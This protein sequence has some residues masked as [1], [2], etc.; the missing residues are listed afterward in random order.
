MKLANNSKGGRIKAT[1]FLVLIALI[2]LFFVG[3]TTLYRD[4]GAPIDLKGVQFKEGETHYGTVLR[5]LG[6]PGKVS[7]VTKGLAFLYEHTLANEKQLGIKLGKL[8]KAAFAKAD[9]N[10]QV[11]LMVFDERGVLQSQKFQAYDENLGIG[12]G[13]QFLIAVKSEVSTSH[14]EDTIGPNQWGVSLLR[15]LPEI[16]NLSQS[17]DTGSAGLEQ[18]GTPTHVGQH[19]LELRS[20]SK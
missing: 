3:C 13:I 17:L 1:Y 7:A 16:M 15:P 6:P 4:I 11:L 8:F 5:Q 10:R 19:T 12:A 2:A 20:S 9:D 14:L 18:S